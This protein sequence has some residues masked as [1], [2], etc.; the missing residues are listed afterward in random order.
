MNGLLKI[1]RSFDKINFYSFSLSIGLILIMLFI[2]GI[3]LDRLPPKLPLFYSLTWGDNQLVPASQLVILPLAATL[4]ML[5][6]LVLSW[7]LHSSQLLLKRLLVI[8]SFIITLMTFITVVKIVY[9]F[10]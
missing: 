3:N 1:Y 2:L 4:I 8:S 5:I 10:I 7:H 9:L 6:N